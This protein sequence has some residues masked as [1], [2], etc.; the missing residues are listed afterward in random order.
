MQSWAKNLEVMQ[1][2]WFY[3]QSLDW[4]SKWAS[5]GEQGEQQYT[6]DFRGLNCIC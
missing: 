4:G 1:A 3:S 2:G 5:P 6:P